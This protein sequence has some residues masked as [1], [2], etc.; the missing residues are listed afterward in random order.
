ML[1]ASY[2]EGALWQAERLYFA[3][4]GA[5]RITLYENGATRPFFVQQGCGPTAIAPYDRGFLVLCH[6][7]A[8]VV[9]TDANGRELRRWDRDRDGVRLIDPNDVTADGNGG[10]YFSDPGRFS[11]AI[12]AE[13]SVMHLSAA[14]VLTRV[15][16]PLWYPN[17]VF[18]DAAHR[19]LYVNEHLSGRILR[20]D[21]RDGG[22]LE[23]P[24]VFADINILARS[25]RYRD[26]YAET[27]PDGVEVGPDGYVYVAIYGAGGVMRFTPEG[28]AA[29]FIETPSRFTTSIGFSE[30]GDA[31]V[32]SVYENA[33][34]PYA[35][36]VRVYS[37]AALTRAIR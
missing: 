12:H 27:G 10:V 37:R 4:M 23:G 11:R 17:G 1:I 22:R 14:G 29:G 6:L 3:E 8:R 18:A 16:G 26:V 35:G 36:E 30:A 34:P 28:D 7:A 33:R 25:R 31:A 20:Y 19:Q 2:P 13:G 5:D 24:S 32:T 21:I 15:A 9:A